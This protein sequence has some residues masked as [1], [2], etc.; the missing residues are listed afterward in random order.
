M[1]GDVLAPGTYRRRDLV[2]FR[3]GEYEHHGLGRFF[4]GLQ[5]GVEGGLGEHVHFVDDVDLEPPGEG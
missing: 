3:R 4:Q 2:G 1:E 5:K